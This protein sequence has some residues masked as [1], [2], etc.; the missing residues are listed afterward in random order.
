[1]VIGTKALGVGELHQAHPAGLT[2]VGAVVGPGDVGIVV[3]DVL[4]GCRPGPG[5][6]V[7]V[8]YLEDLPGH[9]DGGGDD[10][11][12][13]AELEL[14]QGAIFD[15]EMVDGAVR[16]GADEVEIADN[17]PWFGTRR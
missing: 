2:P 12:D 7:V 14:H 8:M 1:M 6:E 9:F 13:G 3:G 5:G 11:T 15:G 17:G 10:E 16:E 4:A